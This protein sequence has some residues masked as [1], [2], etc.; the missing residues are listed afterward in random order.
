MDLKIFA[1][2]ATFYAEAEVG[3]LRFTDLEHLLC[4]GYLD[5]VFI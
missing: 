2:A 5:T 4:G 1:I 3:V